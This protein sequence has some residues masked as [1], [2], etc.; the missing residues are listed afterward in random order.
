MRANAFLFL[1]APGYGLT[2]CIPFEEWHREFFEFRLCRFL[3]Q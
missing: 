2:G 1:P 3:E